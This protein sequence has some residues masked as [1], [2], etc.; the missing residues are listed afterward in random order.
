MIRVGDRAKIVISDSLI[1][2][3]L[4]PLAARWG[5]IVGIVENERN[6]G[7]WIRLDVRFNELF[8]WFVPMKSIRVQEKK[9]DREM[10]ERKNFI[11][12]VMI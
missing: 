7:V 8:C 1:D 5:T 11:N 9:I 4:I 3:K 10:R 6:P 12:S 2:M